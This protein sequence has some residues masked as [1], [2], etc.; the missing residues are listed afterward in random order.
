MRPG[1]LDIKKM[2]LTQVRTNRALTPLKQVSP[3]TPSEFEGG[4]AFKETARTIIMRTKPTDAKGVKVLIVSC[5]PFVTDFLGGLVEAHGYDTEEVSDCH[6]AFV[7]MQNGWPHVVFIDDSC[8]GVENSKNFQLRMQ[9]L[10]Q[11]GVPIIVLIDKH[12]KQHVER[13]P[14]MKFSRIVRKPEGYQQISQIMADLMTV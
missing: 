9:D 8:L 5:N 10:I 1:V 3:L 12:T 2:N 7:Q 6:Q 4:D 11:E 14:K 13:L